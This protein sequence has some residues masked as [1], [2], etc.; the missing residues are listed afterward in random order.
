LPGALAIYDRVDYVKVTPESA[1][2]SFADQTYKKGYLQFEAIGYQRG[3]DGRAHTADDLELGPVE[4]TW[5]VEVFHAPEGSSSDYVGRVSPSGLFVPAAENPGNN[6][7]CW[8]I[9]TAKEEKGQNNA[10]LVGKAY[11]V[12]TI[13]AYL[14]NG[15]QYVRDLDRWVDNGPAQ[16]RR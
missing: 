8:A 1:V 11:M 9:A 7:D 10:P 12:V 16:G 6:F 5:S 15:H 2:A 13:P 3:P 4:V 14:F